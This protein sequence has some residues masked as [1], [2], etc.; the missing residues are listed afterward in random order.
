MTQTSRRAGR[1]WEMAQQ[2][3]AALSRG[4]RVGLWTN[5]E[6]VEVV[7]VVDDPNMRLLEDRSADSAG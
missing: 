5:G 4:K 3:K 7:G 6:F 1:A 2:T